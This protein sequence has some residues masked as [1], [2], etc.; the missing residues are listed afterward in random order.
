[1][2][3][4]FGALFF[5]FSLFFNYGKGS[6]GF[7]NAPRNVLFLC[8]LAANLMLNWVGYPYSVAVSDK[9]SWFYKAGVIVG[10]TLSAFGA[11]YDG[12][13][14]VMLAAQN[15][16][17]GIAVTL[18]WIAAVLFTMMFVVQVF[19]KG[20][21]N[22]ARVYLNAHQHNGGRTF[23]I[24]GLSSRQKILLERLNENQKR[25]TTL[26]LDEYNDKLA[27]EYISSGYTVINAKIDERS[28][29][30][31]GLFNK[32]ESVLIALSAGDENTLAIARLI[33]NHVSC[34]SEEEK[35]KLNFSALIMYTNID[36]AEHFAFSEAAEGRIR[37]FNLYE[38]I[39]RSFLFE[40]PVTRLIPRDFIDRE[41][42][43]IKSNKTVLNVFVGF[44]NANMQILKKS[45]INNQ[46]LGCNYNALVIDSGIE[47]NE[48]SFKNYSAGLFAHFRPEDKDS[49]FPEP[50]ERYNISFRK[51]N[52]LAE[53]FY[54]AVI[55]SI[56]KNDFANVIISLGDDKVSGETAMELRQWAYEND[57]DGNTLKIFVKAKEHSS[58]ISEDVLNAGF[59]Q[60]KESGLIRIEVF[61]FEDEILTIRNIVNEDTDIL[62][63]HIAENYSGD[64]TVNHP[65]SWSRLIN[66][67]RDS[68]RYAALSIRVKLNLM[69]FDLVFDE[70]GETVQDEAVLEE[71][72]AVYGLER[73]HNLRKARAYLEYIERNPDGTILDTSIR[74]NLARLEHQRWNTYYLV[75]GWRPFP[76][77][78]VTAE[79]RKDQR[80]KKHACITTFE[81]LDELARLQARFRTAGLP[82][83][84]P[85]GEREAAYKAAYRDCD[86]MHLDFDQMDCLL[87]NIK[88]TKYRIVREA[89]S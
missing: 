16:L 77:N 39:A 69:G 52:I 73:A 15:D 29:T 12:G 9:L 35:Q 11:R 62:A 1:V 10:M 50:E 67:E 55:E 6:K 56:K 80:K 36:R 72:A 38:I 17:Y 75:N 48:S 41:T 61:G 65:V 45:I 78:L 24:A 33:A 70:T 18:G 42:A 71:F 51:F 3:L 74:N 28:L 68:N 26:I 34:L 64:G 32:H 31:A 81:G 63:K 57:I 47:N 43:R 59:N 5:F 25:R 8:I 30:K 86:T 66:H 88:G 85:A 13:R 37:F 54:D 7:K 40:N 4:V 60:N 49:Y 79:S 58:L 22:S 76:K 2:L 27:K 46:L 82:A 89:R 19:F 87:D 23:I 53:A 84:L 44:G 21:R 20:I 14:T 83:D